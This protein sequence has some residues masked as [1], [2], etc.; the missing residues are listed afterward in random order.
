[1]NPPEEL[2]KNPQLDISQLPA[3]EYLDQV[4]LEPAYKTIRTLSGLMVALVMMLIAWIVVIF[5]PQLWPYGFY[6]AG[7]VSVMA[8]WI[9]YY[10]RISFQ[11]MNYA[12]REKDIS[13]SSGWLW[14]STTTVPFNRVQHCDI[15]QGILDRRFGLSRL[16]I[17]TAGGQSTDLMI[18]GLLPDTAEKLK[19]FILG[20]T[21]QS[22]E[23]D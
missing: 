20:T 21:E 14:R 18:P 8:I 15:K 22:T 7:F 12:M 2:F 13:F 11:Y 3:V 23:E 16:T 4:C 19:S 6:A 10:N 5:R 9:I 1:M 17:Y